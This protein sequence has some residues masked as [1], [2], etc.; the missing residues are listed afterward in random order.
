M[1]GTTRRYFGTDG[2]RAR[3]NAFPLVPDFVVRLGQAAADAFLA[4]RGD[5]R[6]WPLVVIGKDTRQSCDML[7]AAIAA[8]LTSRGIDVRLA[9]VIPT[10]AVAQLTREEGAAFG[11]VISAS[12]NPFEDNGIKFFGPDGYKLDDA[13]EHEIE[14]L[15]DASDQPSYAGPVGRIAPLAHA[16]ERYTAFIRA[17]VGEDRELFRGL[18]LAL[19]AANGAASETSLEI[20]RSLGAKVSVFHHHPSG[21]NINLDCGCTHPEVIGALVRE[22]G[23]AAGVAHDGDADRVLLCDE[24]GS[25]LD[26]DE[27]MALAAISMI[28]AGTLK[29]NTLVATV[30]SNAGL[31]EAVRAAGGRV[32]RAGVGDRYVIEEMKKGGYNLGGEQSGHFI[33]RDH[34]TTGDGI[35]AAVQ[36]LKRMRE[37]GQ[38]L[39]ELRKVMTKFPQVLRNIRVREKRPLAELVAAPRLA[40]LEARLGDAG[41]VLLRYSGTEAL[42][43]LLV[44]GRDAA[45]IEA[46]ADAI[47]AEIRAEIGA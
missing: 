28:R 16:T 46:E 3:A 13:L 42:L 15:V 23:A 5:S 8:G 27:I 36:V 1:S 44:E 39:S 19:D 30:M 40:A 37:S 22:T 11:I 9:G 12:H 29:E 17:S 2:I 20:L 21:I 26:G 7:E 34:N 18:H 47:A 45:F 25:V 33:F 24:T 41:R 6:T 32:V 31:D 38:P 10:P 4:R 43:R 14:S 35:L